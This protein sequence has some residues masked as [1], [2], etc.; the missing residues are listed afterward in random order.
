MRIND[1][2]DYYLTV[3]DIRDQLLRLNVRVYLERT[4]R[5]FDQ[6]RRAY[7]FPAPLVEDA[8][9]QRLADQLFLVEKAEVA[10]RVLSG[11][12]SNSDSRMAT[13][14]DQ[15]G[16]SGGPIRRARHRGIHSSYYKHVDV[17]HN[18]GALNLQP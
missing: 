7:M 3:E 14:G 18:L 16:G 2:N 5:R 9:S 13:E 4:W 8:L 10:A 11:A 6:Y 15:L 1:D 12:D 17:V